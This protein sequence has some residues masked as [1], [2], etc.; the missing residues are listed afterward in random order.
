MHRERVI[1]RGGEGKNSRG[2]DQRGGWGDDTRA[3]GFYEAGG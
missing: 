3:V 2:A 1:E